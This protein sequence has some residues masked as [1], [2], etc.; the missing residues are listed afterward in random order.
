M[1][2]CF[3]LWTAVVLSLWPQEFPGEPGGGQLQNREALASLWPSFWQKPAILAPGHS[4]PPWALTTSSLNSLASY[5]PSHP[6]AASLPSE[7]PPQ[8]MAGHTVRKHEARPLQHPPVGSF[9]GRPSPLRPI[10]WLG[11]GVHHLWDEGS[12]V[13]LLWKCGHTP[14]QEAVGSRGEIPPIFKAFQKS[15]WEA[16][17][18]A[19]LCFPWTAHITFSRGEKNKILGEGHI[20]VRQGWQELRGFK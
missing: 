9:S 2:H 11:V 17:D 15:C 14:I 13:F 12:P 3:P 20:S 6:L 18:R 16:E 1:C 5:P 8:P 4:R 19:C 10:L 7:G